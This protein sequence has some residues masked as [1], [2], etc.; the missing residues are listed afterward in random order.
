MSSIGPN[1]TTVGLAGQVPKEE[2]K[3][4]IPGAFIETPANEDQTFSVKPIPATPGMGNPIKLAPGEKVPDPGSL[5]GNTV[6]STVTTDKASYE[7][8]GAVAASSA[9][10]DDGMFNVPPIQKGMIP[11]SSLPMGG[12]GASDGSAGPFVSSVGPAAT[13]VGLAGQVPLEP[14]AEVPEVVTESQEKAHT[15]AEASGNPIAVE[16]KKEVEEELKSKVQEAPVTSES[17]ITPGNVAGAVTGAAAAAGAAA[18]GIAATAKGKATDV[19][20][21]AS[22]AAQ[23]MVSS[24]EEKTLTPA[25]DTA[26][27]VPEVVTESIKDAHQSAEAASNPEAVLE[28]KEVEAELVKKVAPSEEK[29]EPAPTAGT[30]TD[31]PSD[32]PSTPQKENVK[33]SDET[34]G[35]G[36]SSAKKSKRKSFLLKLKKL[37]K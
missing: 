20:T 30:T 24:T 17:G 33:P 7:S 26:A 2:E 8:G 19:A 12:A 10:K 37:L 5:T 25:A 11:E 35:T 36:A 28:K 21:S 9:S 4:A 22:S 14:K 15:D 3:A 1:A 16:E 6:N 34:P 29:G 18:L 23:G 31:G 32:G 13:T 27:G